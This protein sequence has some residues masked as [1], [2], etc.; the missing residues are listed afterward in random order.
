MMVVLVRLRPLDLEFMRRLS[1]I[2]NVVPVIAKADSLTLEE[3]TEFKQRVRTN[4]RG[5]PGVPRVSPPKPQLKPCIPQ[6]QEDLKAH[7]ISVYPQEDFDQDP[8]D[9]ALNDRIRVSAGMLGLGVLLSLGGTRQHP[10]A[11]MLLCAGRRRSPSPWW[12]RTR[13]TR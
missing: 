13:S 11:S 6:I 1:K 5:A 7:A 10:R 2:V 8:D 9:R 3:R 4:P 12:G